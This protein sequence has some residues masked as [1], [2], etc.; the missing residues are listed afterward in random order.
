MK[1]AVKMCVEGIFH[2]LLYGK[3]F[4]QEDLDNKFQTFDFLGY[5]WHKNPKQALMPKVPKKLKF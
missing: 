5:F 3:K 4:S 1:T 2:D